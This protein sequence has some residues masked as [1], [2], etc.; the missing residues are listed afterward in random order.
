MLT[1]PEQ[2]LGKLKPKLLIEGAQQYHIQRRL[3]LQNL[4][5]FPFTWFQSNADFMWTVKYEDHLLF[6]CPT[7]SIRSGALILVEFSS[8]YFFG[9]GGNGSAAGS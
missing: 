4:Y 9:R 1:H 5:L 8:P 6:S 7:T 3:N 2:K